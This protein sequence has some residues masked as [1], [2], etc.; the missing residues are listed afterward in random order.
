M[1]DI[2]LFRDDIDGIAIKLAKKGYKL[3]IA[4]FNDIESKRKTMQTKTQELQSMRNK[5]S[6]EIGMLMGKGEK[7]QAEVK[8]QEVA[9]INDEL[10]SIEQDLEVLLNEINNKMLEMPN[11]LHDSVPVGKDENDNVEFKTWGTPQEFSFTPKNHVELAPKSAGIDLATS[12][13]LSG[14]RFAVLKNNIAKLH[15]ALAQFM[16]DL[17]T[18]Q[19]GYEEVY[20]PYLVKSDVLYGTGQFPKFKEDQFGI[21]GDDLWLIPTAEVPVTN[22]VRDEILNQETLPLKFACHSSC[23]RREAGSYGKD[24]H[25]LIRQHQF[26]KVELVQIVEPEKSFAAL[27]EL[28]GHAEKVLQLLELPYRV[29]T[30]CSGDTGFSATKTYDIEVWL[31][32]ENK[33]REISSCSNTCDFQAR[34]MQ[35]RFKNK[36]T[37]KNELVHTLNGSGVAVGRALIAVLEN[38][39]NEDGSV[40][41]PEVLKPYMKNIDRVL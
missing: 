7:E 27:D 17:H 21:D 11:I 3:D 29:V 38:Y 35:A 5:S 23:F 20:V 12:S 34:R 6:K 36:D 22:L 37:G 13:K 15:R 19:H 2:K 8:K 33:Y 28:L 18:E 39:Q 16:L 10:K 30:L 9:K 31:P 41:V 1:L 25:G 32:S 24:T 4:W 40:T 14:S 26:E